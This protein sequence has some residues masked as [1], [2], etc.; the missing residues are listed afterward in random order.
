MT[1]NRSNLIDLFDRAKVT[2]VAYLLVIVKLASVSISELREITGDDAGTISKYLTRL[3]SRGL[4]V[5]VQD[6]TG[7][8][9]HPSAD[10]TLQI[11][12]SGQSLQSGKFF[13]ELSSS[14]NQSVQSS[15]I[16]SDKIQ[17]E[18]EEKPDKDF[19]AWLCNHYGLTGE[20]ARSIIANDRIWGEDICAWMYHVGQMKRDGYK[21]RKSAEAY[22]CACLLKPDGPDEPPQTAL[23]NSGVDWYWSQFEKHLEYAKDTP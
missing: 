6:G 21:F 10:A 4:L 19:K 9:W 13:P 18:E 22:A 8:R 3:E 23:N 11:Q 5:R 16:E 12:S 14:S 17:S 2:G 20:R 7:H 15:V 1:D